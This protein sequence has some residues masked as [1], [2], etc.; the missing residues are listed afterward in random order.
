[1]PDN[2]DPSIS[3]PASS[4]VIAYRQAEPSRF[5]LLLRAL[6]HRNYRLFFA[7]QIVSLVGTFLTQLA[8]VWYVY[9][10]THSELLLGVVGFAGQIPMFLLA[11]FAGV[12]VD[13]WEL[14]RLLVITQA[15]S[16]LQSLGLAA[17]AYF[18]GREHQQL[19]VGMFIGLAVLQGLINA[20]DMPARQAFLVEM[21][22]R[23]EDLGNAIA[24]NST[25][26]HGARL[27]GPALAGILIQ[28]VGPSLCFLMDGCS[29]IAVIFALLAMHVLPRPARTIERS[30]LAELKDGLRYAWQFRPIRVLL[31]S[32]SL[33]SLTGMPAFTVLMPVFGEYFGGKAASARTLGLLMGASGLGA[34]FGALYLAA[35]PT[36]VGLGRVM[37]GA[38]FAFGVALIG[39][40][41]CHQFWL[42]MLVVPIAGCGMLLSFASAN[43]LIQTLTDDAMRGRVMSLF[44]MAFVGMAPWGN[45][46]AGAASN[47][48]AKG[49]SN[50][51]V[52]ASRTLMFA[53][54]IVLIGCARFAFKLPGLRQ[55]IRPIYVQKGILPAE[56]AT[57][58]QV[59]T[60][61]VKG[62]EH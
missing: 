54:A 26:V 39:F 13:R 12:W 58:M 40:A 59:A 27:I 34:L 37:V 2:I 61:E 42:A 3:Q 11:P 35:R 25:M 57:G 22:P 55:I 9:D 19:I 15:L 36:V 41:F 30:M 7:G 47:A 51:A 1:M 23:R 31:I 29:Y 18:A 43:T 38:M 20:F 17:M 49:T 48:M 44:S 10:L 16:M 6:S 32:M 62:P 24:L 50:A 46:L 14:R 4:D 28:Y 52:G 5:H 33:L 53:G 45:L 56:I 21:V 60:E 8:T